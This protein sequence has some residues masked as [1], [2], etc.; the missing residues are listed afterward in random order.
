MRLVDRP[1]DVVTTDEPA[2][3]M[4]RFLEHGSN[5]VSSAIG[6][7]KWRPGQL[8]GKNGSDAETMSL[9]P[10]YISSKRRKETSERRSATSAGH[11]A[12]HRRPRDV[13]VGW[14]GYDEFID[15][16]SYGRQVTKAMVEELDD[17]WPT[18]L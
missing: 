15:W 14:G 9:S 4:M 2:N 18:D 16:Q 6:E 8:I 7:E 10:S 1:V 12:I 17:D 3:D 13:P 11:F 5:L